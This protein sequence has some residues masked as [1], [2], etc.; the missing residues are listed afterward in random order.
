MHL[1]QESAHKGLFGAFADSLPDGWGTLLMDRIFRQHQIEPYQLTPMDRLAYIGDRALG[2]LTYEP[3]NAFLS[4]NN[5]QNDNIDLF[6]LG[7]EAQ[8]V[9]EGQTD[10]ILLQLANAGSSGGARPKAQIYFNQKISQQVSTIEKPHLDPWLIKFT[11]ASLP[12]K[13]EEGLCEAAYLTM[14]KNVGIDVPEYSI[15]HINS[16]H[17]LAMRRF[18]CTLTGGRYH[19]QSLC[20]LLDADYRIPSLDYLDI[21]KTGQILCQNPAV[22]QL[23]FMRALFNLF[24]LNQDD[25]SKNWAFLQ[26]DA[27]NWYPAPFYDITFSP[28]ASNEHATAFCGYG[29]TP[30]K[31]AIQELAAQANLNWTSAKQIMDKIVTEIQSFPTIAREFD[32]SKTTI[33]MINSA[34]NKIYQNN[35]A[36][37]S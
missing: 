11:S 37:L 14:A 29:K 26:N 9:F 35:K 36:I 2:A 19:L 27:G 5:L 4:E 16:F 13:H 1:C 25:H 34:Q 7:N 23:F 21:I 6:T 32:I 30:P 12:L 15:M 8:A 28:S 3:H 17:W 10:K 20:A 22:G 24:A 31:K 33:K 18:D